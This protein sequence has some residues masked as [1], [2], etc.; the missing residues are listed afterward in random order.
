MLIETVRKNMGVFTHKEIE[1][2]K[3][4]RQTQGRVGNPPDREFKQLIGT[5][6]L[7]NNP[8]IIENVS[9]AFAIF[10]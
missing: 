3:L 4:Y 1:G 7:K 8:V 10:G 9:D 2:S 6:A 5:N